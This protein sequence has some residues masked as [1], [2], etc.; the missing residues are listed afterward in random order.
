[1]NLNRHNKNTRIRR[2]IENIDYNQILNFFNKRADRYEEEHPYSVTMFQDN[3]LA[4]VDARNKAETEKL[5]PLLRLDTTS[6]VLD[7]ACGIGRWSDV[8]TTQI[9]EYFGIDFSEQLIEL[10]KKRPHEVNRSF[11]VGA[12]SN[13]QNV[14]AANQ[15]S[16]F[17]RFLLVGILMYINDRDLMSVMN[18]MIKASEEHAIIC[19]REPVGIDERLT[20]KEFYS[21]ELNDNYNAIYRTRD[22]LMRVFE[23]TLLRD[24]FNIMQSGFLFLEDELNNRKETAQYYFVLEK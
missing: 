21:E 23:Q 17:N 12:L 2:N 18:Q 16:K 11:C 24:G 19:I 6:K 14:L 22:E 3:N 15:K 7:L 5:L 1:M 13:L 20:L 10:A 4:L 8:I 9:A